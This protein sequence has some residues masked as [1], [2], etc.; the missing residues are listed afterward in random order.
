MADELTPQQEMARAMASDLSEIA[1]DLGGPVETASG[2]K[3]RRLLQEARGEVDR[4]TAELAR[5]R[6]G[7]EWF[8][9]EGH[10]T[11]TYRQGAGYADVFGARFARELLAG[12]TIEQIED[13]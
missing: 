2:R 1:L 10:Y 4:L 6:A 7:L 11:A 12:K 9:D 3:A 8:A 13:E 5:L